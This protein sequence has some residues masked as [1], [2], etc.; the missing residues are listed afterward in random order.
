MG[1]SLH[2][3]R[4]CRSEHADCNQSCNKKPDLKIFHGYRRKAYHGCSGSSRRAVE[5]MLPHRPHSAPPRGRTGGRLFT[6]AAFGA[7]IR[8]SAPPTCSHPREIHLAVGMAT[9]HPPPARAPPTG[10]D[11]GRL[12]KRP[13]GRAEAYGRD[14]P[15][16]GPSARP[17]NSTPAH[18]FDGKDL[19]AAVPRRCS[20]VRGRT[21]SIGGRAIVASHLSAP[22]IGSAQAARRT[23]PAL[24]PFSLFAVG[25]SILQ[26]RVAAPKPAAVKSRPP[27]LRCAHPIPGRPPI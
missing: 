18:P 3:M 14:Q 26:G 24:S 11:G 13:G 10:G 7:A 5:T 2:L 8:P 16:S 12:L 6:A 4:H 22:Q 15:S 17:P 25:A 9:F 23:A 27:V 20:S 1:D 21:R 19:R